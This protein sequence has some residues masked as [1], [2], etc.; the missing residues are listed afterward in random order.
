M[1]E[2]HFTKLEN[3]LEKAGLLTDE[4]RSKVRH[5]Q[6]KREGRDQTFQEKDYFFNE[7]APEPKQD[8]SEVT[9]VLRPAVLEDLKEKEV[10]VEYD[11]KIMKAFLTLPEEPRAVSLE[12]LEEFLKMKGVVFGLN[13]NSLENAVDRYKA[14]LPV[15]GFEV[16]RGREPVQGTS[17]VVHIYFETEAHMR[18]AESITDSEE[19][20]FRDSVFFHTVKAGTVLAEKLPMIEG[21]EGINVRGRTV[22]PTP[23]FDVPFV[24]GINTVINDSGQLMALEDGRPVYR[25]PGTISVAK[26]FRVMG[27]L[28]MKTGNID[29]P[30]D[31]EIYGN[32]PSGFKVKAGGRIVVT[33]SVEA[34]RLH[35]E[36]DIV[37][38]AGYFGG[39]SGYLFAGRDISLTHCNGGTVEARGNLYVSREMVN[40]RVFVGGN[41]ECTQVD[42]SIIGGHIYIGKDMYVFHLGSELGASTFVYMGDKKILMAR[43][44]EISQN[45]EELEFEDNLLVKA[46]RRLN[47][48]QVKEDMPQEQVSAIMNQLENSRL[49]FKEEKRIMQEQH[50]KLLAKAHKYSLNRVCVGGKLYPGVRLY[51]GNA[52]FHNLKQQSNLEFYQEPQ[53]LKI[54]SRPYYL[55]KRRTL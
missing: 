48:H 46:I 20:D 10:K 38:Q 50:K 1:A 26:A 21:Q 7:P 12:Q 25:A 43:I 42:S 33:G 2:E 11:D 47:R 29:F 14:G 40:A 39:S 28:D 18:S 37:I 5:F 19:G 23:V 27:S 51:L 9:A 24:A 31:V 16:A 54:R 49:K 52:Q 55:S 30:G 13:L 8:I 34:A 22:A 6:K 41:L 44:R 35:A 32:I 17:A 53:T 15:A 4:E 36:D 3:L 45:L